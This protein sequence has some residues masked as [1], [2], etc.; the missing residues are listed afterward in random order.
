[1]MKKN[2]LF[3]TLL[4]LLLTACSQKQTFPDTREGS[5]TIADA[6]TELHENFPGIVE[7]AT[8]S[9]S[10]SNKLV[11]I[12]IRF[13]GEKIPTQSAQ[14]KIFESLLADAALK[15]KKPDWKQLFKDVEVDFVSLA[16]N[17]QN[18][19]GEEVLLATKKKNRTELEFVD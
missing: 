5:R 11:R 8:N 14:Q 19:T 9:Y 3:F 2:V 18:S 13:E 1:M 17:K 12:G 15:A 16:P 6:A 7:F 10:D 4:I